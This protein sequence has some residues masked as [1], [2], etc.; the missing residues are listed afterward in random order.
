MQI[1]VAR[2]TLY[3]GYVEALRSE[4]GHEAAMHRPAIE[5]DS[6]GAAIAG[7][8]TLLHR[9]PSHFAQAGAQALARLRVPQ[10][11]LAVDDVA[12]DYLASSSRRISSAKWRV[13]CLRYSGV[14]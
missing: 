5:P 7:V 14:P 11:S 13:K 1:A 8:T 6:T 2:E 9:E 4:G 12:H 10:E 3:S